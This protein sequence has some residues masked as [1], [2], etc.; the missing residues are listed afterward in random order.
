MRKLRWIIISLFACV[1]ITVAQDDIS[2]ALSEQLAGIE[3]ITADL[4]QLER[5]IAIELAFPSSRELRAQL[6]A[7]IT[8]Q[9]AEGE[10]EED[11]LF[12]VALDLLPR[13]IDIESIFLEFL[14]TQVQGF[15][16]SEIKIMH[17]ISD[18]EERDETLNILENVT[19]AHEFVHALQDQYF[20]IDALLTR[21]EETDNQ[22]YALALRSLVEGDAQQVTFQYVLALAQE[23]PGAISQLAELEDDSIPDDVPDIII[24]ELL[25]PYFEGH[26]FVRTLFNEGRW[27]L[28]NQAYIDLPQ[29]TEHIYHPDRYLAGDNPIAVSAP[30]LSEK[31]GDEWRLIHDTVVGEFYLRQHIATQLQRNT[32]AITTGWGGDNVKIYLNDRTGELVWILDQVW[33]TPV[34]AVEFIEGYV[35]FLNVRYDSAPIDHCWIG[36]ADSMCLMQLTDDS[37]RIVSAPRYDLALSLLLTRS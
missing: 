9:Y 10:L 33:D 15:Y 24:N 7:D 29:S 20:D 2:P 18:S 26:D 22:D 28:V 8:E 23:D 30:D 37:T 25:Y 11:M 5:Q 17:I 4:R 3:A 21:I 12:Y 31:L 1:S 36:S 13:D 27:E 34:D 35:R 14:T 32:N 16:D 19:Y 6:E